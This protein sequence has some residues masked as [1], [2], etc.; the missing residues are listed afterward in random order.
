MASLPAPKTKL[1]KRL[2][3]SQRQFFQ[4]FYREAHP[5]QWVKNEMDKLSISLRDVS[6]ENFA[7][8]SV[9]AVLKCFVL[10]DSDTLTVR[11]LGETANVSGM[12][13]SGTSRIKIGGLI[14]LCQLVSSISHSGERGTRTLETGE[15]MG[16]G[17]KSRKRNSFSECVSDLPCQ[18][19]PSFVRRQ[20][21]SSSD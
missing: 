16:K 13:R 15:V 11:M 10:I 12:R 20:E 4:W 21:Q 5:I 18:F 3:P 17:L 1:T 9:S 2:Q 19:L 7:A 8:R 14:S 6:G